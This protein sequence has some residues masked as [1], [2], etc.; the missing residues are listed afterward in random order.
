MRLTT[1]L[2]TVS[3]W[4]LTS[5]SAWAQELP[6]PTSEEQTAQPAFRLDGDA[7]F[8]TGPDMMI[9]QIQ[10]PCIGLDLMATDEAAYIACGLDGLLVVPLPIDT[11]DVEFHLRGMGGAVTSLFQAQGQTWAEVTRREARPVSE[12]VST[13]PISVS[14]GAA[15]VSTEPAGTESADETAVLVGS[16]IEVESGQVVIDLGSEAGV[17]RGN[18]IELFVET[19][20]QTSGGETAIQ[21]DRVAI[22]E[23]VAVSETRSRV[24]LGLNERVSLNARARLTNLD[25]T[26]DVWAPARVGDIWDVAFVARPFLALGTVGVGMVSEVTVGYRFE[27]PLA[28]HL[29]LD[30]VGIGLAE[31]GN[32]LAIAG[33]AIV[34][35]DVDSFQVGLGLGWSAVNDELTSGFA[36]AEDASG[37]GD[38]IE[39]DQVRSGLS[40]AQYARLGSRDGLHLAGLNSFILYDDEFV[41][42]GT[43]SLIQVPLITEGPHQLW[44]I[45]RG[46]GGRSGYVF[47]EAGLRVLASGNGDQGSFYITPT[48]G[49][50]SLWGEEDI[51]CG[52]Y[53]Y[54]YDG[55]GVCT[56]DVDYGGPM[57]G[58]GLEWRL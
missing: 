46:G 30:P 54:D 40:I 32:V 23:A 20:V 28:V 39:F 9:H 58:I 14:I 50:A 13:T 42:G 35:Y 44:L 37:S 51:D 36:L 11:S 3:L 17:A 18:H 27:Q 26:G 57:V 47:G 43:S 45:F 24:S 2:M 21:E 52:E 31:E 34:S 5:H 6:D 25:L 10:L 22:G 29:M 55:D 41:Y 8:Y 16:V 56:R 48:I 1:A 19:S 4:G 33:N 53:D 12:T 15:V 7:F 38:G 49:G